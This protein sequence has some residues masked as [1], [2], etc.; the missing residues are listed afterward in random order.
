MSKLTAQH[1]ASM[2]DLPEVAATPVA[3]SVTWPAIA[4]LQT[5]RGKG[6]ARLLLAAV[7]EAIKVVTFVQAMVSPT[8]GLLH[9]INVVGPI[10]MLVTVKRRQ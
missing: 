9:V 5:C 6:K 2:V 3:K 4:Q 8:T 10:I 1:C 7:V